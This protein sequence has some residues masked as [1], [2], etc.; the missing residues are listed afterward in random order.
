MSRLGKFKGVT[1][2][3][4]PLLIHPDRLTDKKLTSTIK[5]MAERIGK[6]SF[7]FQQNAIMGR[8]DGARDLGRIQCDTLV[9]CGRQDALIS[10]DLHREMAA[11][12]PHSTLSVIENCGHLSTLERPEAVNA[13]LRDWLLRE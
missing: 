10:F 3:L 8:S 11:K 5:K 6:D 1:D 2:R 9:L 4:M 7:V 12:I 13:A